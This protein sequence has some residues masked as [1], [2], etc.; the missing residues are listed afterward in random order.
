MPP[1]AAAPASAMALQIR[2][3]FRDFCDTL[4]SANDGTLLAADYPPMSYP[5]PARTAA[6]SSAAADEYRRVRA[7]TEALCIP[8]ACEDY[9]VQSMP[10]ASPVKWHLAHT[11]WFFEE[12]VLS[13][14]VP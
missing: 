12:F 5:L 4:Y 9:V 3:G 14:Y 11:S 2:T 13:T 8:L 10:E 7:A 1:R 6:P